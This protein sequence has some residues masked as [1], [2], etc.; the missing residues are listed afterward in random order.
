MRFVFEFL[1]FNE[2]LMDFRQ[3]LILSCEDNRDK[4]YN[5]RQLRKIFF[6]CENIKAKNYHDI[7][8]D[9]EEILLL[10]FKMKHKTKGSYCLSKIKLKI[11]EQGGLINRLPSLNELFE[12]YKHRLESLIEI[13]R[14]GC[15]LQYL[16]D[17]HIYCNG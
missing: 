2:K 8:Q 9:L 11:Y 3:F 14:E 16:S 15:Q 7:D 12:F 1:E 13:E 5:L 17:N 4:N 6:I 10:I